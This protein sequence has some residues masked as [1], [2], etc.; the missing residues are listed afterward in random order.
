[1]F[2]STLQIVKIEKSL[3]FSISSDSC[4]IIL[5]RPKMESIFNGDEQTFWQLS[6]TL[7]IFFST[8]QR[9]KIEKM[10]KIFNFISASL[11]THAALFIGG[12]NGVIF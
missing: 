8:L 4:N 7:A 1:M 11:V 5:W 10:F 2:F 3:R 6:V 12:K 9:A